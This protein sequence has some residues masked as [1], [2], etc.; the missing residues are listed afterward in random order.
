MSLAAHRASNECNGM[1][2]SQD[3]RSR[4]P[5]YNRSEPDTTH[6]LP[7]SDGYTKIKSK[8]DE[9][10]DST[11]TVSKRSSLALLCVTFLTALA[12]LYITYS[13]FP[14]LHEEEKV[15]M[16]L[17]RNM[18]DARQLGLVLTKHKT[19]YYL[20]VLSAF[21]ITY[22]FLQTFAI[23]GSIFLSVLSGYLFPPYQ[24]LLL[25]CS[26]SALGASCCY[27]LFSVVGRG[28]VVRYFP[29]RVRSW[30]DQVDR[31]REHML[32]YMIFLRITPFLPNWFINIASPVISVNYMPFVLGTFIGVAPPSFLAIQTGTT[33]YDMTES[34]SNFTWSRLIFLAGL[35]TLSLLPVLYKTKLKNRLE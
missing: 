7:E 13:Y 33:L 31:H 25:V 3:V 1:S 11:N 21:S 6:D 10:P 22:I 12:I 5:L 19:Q 2:S 17:P 20:Q 34:T 9:L 23:P 16:K 32:N 18:E 26:C 15:H 28:L 24:A 27:G 4:R 14:K 8:R 30:S 29:D 35:A